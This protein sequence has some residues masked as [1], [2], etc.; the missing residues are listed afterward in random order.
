[1]GGFMPANFSYII[2]GLLAGCAHPGHSCDLRSDLNRFRDEGIALVISLTERPLNPQILAEAGL[3]GHHVP[4]LDFHPPTLEQIAEFAEVVKS[5][6]DSGTGG[7]VVHCHAG[8]GRTGTML[9]AY[10]ISAGM[11]AREAIARVRALRPGSI[12]THEQEAVLH[13]YEEIVARRKK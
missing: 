5:Q 4:I 7:V 1:M 11:T 8:V 2:E 10:L 6:I 9:A 3:R 13:Q 12:E